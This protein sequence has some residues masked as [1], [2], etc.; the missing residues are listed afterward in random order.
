MP[1]IEFVYE[2]VDFLS[3]S[4]GFIDRGADNNIYEDW[5]SKTDE[6]DDFGWSFIYKDSFSKCSKAV[7]LAW[8]DFWFEKGWL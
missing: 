8:W 4:A 6:F 1:D 2:F 3:I 7:N 5:C